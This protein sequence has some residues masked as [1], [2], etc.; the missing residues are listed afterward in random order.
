MVENNR[1]AERQQHAFRLARGGV[2]LV[3]V[4]AA[5]RL[6]TGLSGL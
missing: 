3:V 2:D 5:G 4:V 6:V 1:I